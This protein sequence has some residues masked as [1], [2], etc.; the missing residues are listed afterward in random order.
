[1]FFNVKAVSPAQF[2]NWLSAQQAAVKNGTASGQKLPNGLNNNSGGGN[3]SNNN[4]GGDL[5]GD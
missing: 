5:Y 1:M 3:S 4:E 2:A